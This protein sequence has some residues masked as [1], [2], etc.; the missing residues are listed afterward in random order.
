MLQVLRTSSLLLIFLTCPLALA[1]QPLQGHQ[2]DPAMAERLRKLEQRLSELESKQPPTAPEKEEDAEHLDEIEQRLDEVEKRSVLDRLTLGGEYRTIFNAFFYHGPSPDPLDR[3][4]NNPLRPRQ[5]DD[6]SLEVWSHRVRISLAAQPIPSLRFTA[7]LVMFKHFGDA[8]QAAYITDNNSSRVPRDSTARFD[9]AWIDWF[10]LDWLALSVGRM[11]YT[12]VNPPGELKENSPGRQA[13]WG[14]QMVDGE[15][16]TLNVTLDFSSLVDDLFL[17]LFYA[18][19]F[20]DN[21]DVLGGMP[22][23]NSGTD[24]LRIF[25]L[26]IDLR[27]PFLDRGFVQ[28][29]YYNIPEFKPFNMPIADPSFDRSKDHTHRP[30]NH[31]IYPSKLP[32]S[33]GMYQNISWLVE[34]LDLASS[35]LDIFVAGSVGFLSPNDEAIEYDLVTDPSKPTARSST[36]TLFL[37][38]HG[39]QGTTVFVY[40]GLRYTVPLEVLNRPKIG[41]E[42]NYGSRYHISFTTNTDQLVSK[43]STRGMAY[44]AYLIFPVNKHLFLRAGYLFMDSQF[45]V[46]FFGPD[47]KVAGS[48]APEVPQKIHNL[49]V[50][51]NASI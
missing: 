3:D 2:P 46:G 20:N 22:F 17:R 14:L 31:L 39:D 18:S 43:L 40:T 4:P 41:F 15:Y 26:N 45:Q 8:D 48:T 6:E 50:V 1:Q 32:D 51:L 19:W 27:L 13:T 28:V 21:D 37:S 12:D 11:S 16:E 33:L 35:G 5:V 38:S 42:F 23:L 29:G 10:I 25:G 7:R 24:N 36:P 9:Q 49:N 34:V 44:E 47:P 30:G